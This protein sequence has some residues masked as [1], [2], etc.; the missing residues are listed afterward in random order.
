MTESIN[1][2]V[3]R[4]AYTMNEAAVSLGVS[5]ST[6]SRMVASGEVET[7]TFGRSRR[8]PRSVL[9]ALVGGD[10]AGVGGLAAEAS[11]PP[12]KR[13]LLLVEIDTLAGREPEVRVFLN[14]MQ[15]VR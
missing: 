3:S 12:V 14:G 7:V 13:T 4:L 15:V 11:K 9:A 5:R 6:M 10:P 8:V 2:A 1:A